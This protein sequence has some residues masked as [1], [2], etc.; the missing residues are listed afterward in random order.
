MLKGRAG[1]KVAVD[2]KVG[3]TLLSEIQLLFYLNSAIEYKTASFP[4]ILKVFNK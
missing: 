4:H 2:R 3:V 1:K